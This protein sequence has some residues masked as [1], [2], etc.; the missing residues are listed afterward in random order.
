[1]SNEEIE[2]KLLALE[3][4]NLSSDYMD[5]FNWLHEGPKRDALDAVYE[6]CLLLIEQNN[7]LRK[8]NYLLKN[9]I[10]EP[11]QKFFPMSTSAKKRF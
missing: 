10:P 5:V 8:E 1:M 9:P 7:N 4:S 6:Y 3:E 11:E 2:A